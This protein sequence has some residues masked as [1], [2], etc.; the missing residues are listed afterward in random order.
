MKERRA[1]AKKTKVNE[2]QSISK[3]QRHADPIVT[4]FP[5][6]PPSLNLI[7]RIITDYC[8]DTTPSAFQEAGCAV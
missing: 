3:Q 4:K 6:A 1:N 2:A 8:Q 5:P 7:H